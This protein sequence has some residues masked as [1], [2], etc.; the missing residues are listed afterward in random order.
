[1]S[2][3][4]GTL[5]HSHIGEW[6]SVQYFSISKRWKETRNSI[7]EHCVRTCRSSRIYS[8]NEL[9]HSCQFYLYFLQSIL[10]LFTS[11]IL[12]VLAKPFFFQCFVSIVSA[13]QRDQTNLDSCFLNSSNLKTKTKCFSE[14]SVEFQRTL[15]KVRIRVT[16]RHTIYHQSV[17][18]GDKPLETHDQ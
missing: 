15:Y 7:Y 12:S 4:N 16:S 13:Y 17:L 5:E 10:F 18:L 8:Q 3:S 14:T 2:F 1:M 11:S 9:H 6:S